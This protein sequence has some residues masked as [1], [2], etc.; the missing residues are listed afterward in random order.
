MRAVVVAVVLGVALAMAVTA[1][2]PG[3]PRCGPVHIAKWH[4]P[5]LFARLGEDWAPRLPRAGLGV[6]GGPVPPGANVT[7]L[8][9]EAAVGPLERLGFEEGMLKARLREDVLY[10]SDNRDALV[11]WMSRH[12]ADDPLAAATRLQ[13]PPDHGNVRVPLDPLLLAGA[14]AAALEQDADPRT[15]IG[16][17]SFHGPRWE[18]VWEVPVK[19]KR[20]GSAAGS[21][22]VHVDS[23]GAVEARSAG[24]TRDDAERAV[25]DM[26]DGAVMQVPGGMQL[27]PI[28][29]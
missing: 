26:L 12:G 28:V 19:V 14:W 10:G 18:A 11:A 24:L 13:V 17:G 9:Y 22:S 2:Q 4:D 7:S 5:T 6:E 21:V 27:S 20:V 16:R 29:C 8:S 23:T 15:D 1:S 3:Y 25:V